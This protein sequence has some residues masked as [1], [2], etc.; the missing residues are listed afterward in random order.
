LAELEDR[1]PDFK[2]EVGSWSTVGEA[3]EMTLRHVTVGRDI[4]ILLLGNC[5]STEFLHLLVCVIWV[6]LS[7]K[8][9]PFMFRVGGSII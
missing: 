5:A 8:L 3:N 9:S 4:E 6:G 1:R 2:F 7:L